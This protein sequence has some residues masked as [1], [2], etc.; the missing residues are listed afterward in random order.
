MDSKHK[1]VMMVDD[2]CA[3]CFDMVYIDLLKKKLASSVL[4]VVAKRKF[5]RE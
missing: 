4:F 3:C 5:V 1:K 2:S